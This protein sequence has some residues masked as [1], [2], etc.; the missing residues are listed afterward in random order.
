[1]S[2]SNSTY[3]KM[4]AACMAKGMKGIY[5]VCIAGACMTG[6][7]VCTCVRCCCDDITWHQVE[8]LRTCVAVMTNFPAMFALVIIIFCASATFSLGTW[9]T[10]AKKKSKQQLGTHHCRQT[11]SA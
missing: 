2:A 6:C 3:S 4:C 5:H 9:R 10:G 7:K 1:M 8:T 11:A